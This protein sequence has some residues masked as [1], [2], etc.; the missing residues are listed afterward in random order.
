MRSFL[1][2]NW[3][4]RTFWPTRLKSES[5]VG[6]HGGHLGEFRLAEPRT[7]SADGFDPSAVSVG[8]AIR[9]P[10]LKA[11]ES[12]VKVRYQG[13]SGRYLLRASISHF[14]PNR[15][16][17]PAGERCAHLIDYRVG[18]DRSR[19]RCARRSKSLPTKSSRSPAG[20]NSSRTQLHP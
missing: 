9:S 7:V 5:G 20:R 13:Q 1:E 10:G 15:T 17:V 3:C 2:R 14:D 4:G 12:F 11:C 18:A 19:A 8:G 16:F 6:L